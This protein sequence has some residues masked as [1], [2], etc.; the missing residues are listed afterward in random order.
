MHILLT[1]SYFPSIS[2]MRAVFAAN[3]IT[4]EQNETFQKK[5]LRNRCSIYAANG[6]INLS[7]PIVKRTSDIQT[8]KDAKIDY[9]TNWQKQHFK[10]IESAY[11]SS[12][13]YEYIIDDFLVFFSGKYKYLL[14]LNNEILQRVLDFFEINR[15]I[16]FT[17]SYNSNFNNGLD[18]RYLVEKN[19]NF[20]NKFISEKEYY[21]VFKDKHGF[22]SDLSILDLLFNLGN[23]SYSYLIS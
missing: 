10:S 1:T 11:N 8:I 17:N 23:E 9:S 3:N 12:P 21:Q 15:N 14:D 7:V 16:D 20:D 2:Y 4:I 13:F 6:R 5:T 22:I 19:K 18:L